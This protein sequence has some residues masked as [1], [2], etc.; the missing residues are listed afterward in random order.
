MCSKSNFCRLDALAKYDLPAELN[1]VAKVTGKARKIIY[2]AHSMGTTVGLMYASETNENLVEKY[3]ML[4]PVA[5]MHGLRFIDAVMPIVRSI[6][7]S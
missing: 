7:V 6:F 4:A 2:L 5:Y 1:F 3:V